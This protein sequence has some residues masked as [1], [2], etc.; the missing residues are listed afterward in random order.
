[1]SRSRLRVSLAVC[2][3]TTL[4]GGDLTSA[5]PTS[6]TMEQLIAD[7]SWFG[8]DPEVADEYLMKAE[9]ETVILCFR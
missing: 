6:I 8:L 5:T 7:F 3:R 1:M 4:S 9:W 2:W